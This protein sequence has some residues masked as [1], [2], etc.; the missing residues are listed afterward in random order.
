MKKLLS[1]LLFLITLFIYCED[2]FLLQFIPK[3][4]NLFTHEYYYTNYN[5][6][7]KI[8]NWNIYRLTKDRSSNNVLTR[9]SIA[10]TK[11]PLISNSCSPLEYILCGCDKG[12]LIPADDCRFNIIALRE[13]FFMSNICPQYPEFN[14]GIWKKL[15][16][17]IR[18]WVEKDNRNVIII[19][20]VVIDYKHI[21]T[22]GKSKIYIP[23]A[24]FKIIYDYDN[25]EAISF[26]IPHNK[27]FSRTD[28][29]YFIKTIKEIEDIIKVKFKFSDRVK[30]NIGNFNL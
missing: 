23:I 21:N 1:I 8:C 17:K 24:F 4:N 7:T 27:E 19:T 16:T 26:L 9:I 3:D 18:Y 22:I 28:L 29:K 14:R 15:E 20:G 11:D 6:I 12:H 10:F 30:N 2:T 5:Q 25:K 13:A